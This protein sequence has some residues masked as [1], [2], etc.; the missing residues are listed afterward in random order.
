MAILN[1][2]NGNDTLNGGNGKD[3][4][5]GGDGIDTLNGGNGKDIVVGGKGDDIA[6]LGNGND[7]FIWN[8]GDGNDT[9]DGGNGFDT[10]DF[11]GADK[12]ETITISANP[13]GP[14]FIRA[15]GNMTLTSVERIQFEAQGVHADD[16]EIKDLTGTGVEQVAIDV[17]A[18]ADSITI[19]D[20]TGTDLKK[21]TID[22]GADDQADTVNINSTNGQ[23]ITFTDNKGVVT[24]SGLASDVTISNFDP[25]VDQLVING[26]PQTVMEGQTGT[27]TAENSN[28]TGGTSTA[29]D[30]SNA[31]GLALLGQ[32]MA[33][34]FVTTGDSHGATP[35]ADQPS[36][37]QALL[38][39]PH[40]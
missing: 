23:A 25:R 15:A 34:S 9:V 6:L 19:N 30:G 14:Q 36:S 5:N 13:G 17:G 26:Q 29:S 1:G 16:I 10:L 20:V 31:T 21:V 7:K 3:T 2:G 24:V 22:L 35:T 33:S 4:L 28:N 18:G 12:A 37:H 38:T 32:A 40:A 27:V 11:H 8:P 39:H